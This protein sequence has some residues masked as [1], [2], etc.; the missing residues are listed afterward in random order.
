[1]IFERVDKL[2]LA[3]RQELKKAIAD[4]ADWV[5]FSREYLQSI[6]KVYRVN[7]SLM[8]VR[9]DGSAVFI[10]AYVGKDLLKVFRPAIEH[11]KQRGFKEL[12][13]A[14]SQPALVKLIQ[15]EWVTKLVSQV[16]NYTIYQV[17]I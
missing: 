16:N 9:G 1:M 13:F 8:V 17:D 4:P 10:W 11:F 14:T 6:V 2:S 7:Q 5:Q 3:D 12:R 15:K